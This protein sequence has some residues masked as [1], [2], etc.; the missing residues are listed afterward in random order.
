MGWDDTNAPVDTL[1]VLHDLVQTGDEVGAVD[2][3]QGSVI[4]AQGL[5]LV[6]QLLP[7]RVRR[8][9]RPLFPPV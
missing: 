2:L 4:P 5:G 6:D 8:E 7:A 1:D 3:G 9:E